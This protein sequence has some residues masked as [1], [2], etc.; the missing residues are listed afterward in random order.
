MN[1]YALKSDIPSGGESSSPTIEYNAS[2]D[3]SLSGVYTL[4]KKNQ[5]I[6]LE[7]LYFQH[8]KIL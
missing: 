4:L 6:L 1:I 3:T 8:L 7:I 2:I 5:N